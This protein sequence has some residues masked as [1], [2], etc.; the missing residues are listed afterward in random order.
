M[1]WVKKIAPGGGAG[2]KVQLMST[3]HSG[4]HFADV[5]DEPSAVL[6]VVYGLDLHHRGL[7]TT[8]ILGETRQ[9]TSSAPMMYTHTI[10]TGIA[11]QQIAQMKFLV[12]LHTR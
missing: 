5:V 3:W 2:D 4:G 6:S 8:L 10:S 11:L 9:K 7:H 1:S 12:F